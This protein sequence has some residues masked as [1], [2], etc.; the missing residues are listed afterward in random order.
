MKYEPQIKQKIRYMEHHLNQ[1][2]TITAKI[3]ENED[4]IPLFAN[5]HAFFW[6]CRSILESVALDVFDK[7]GDKPEHLNFFDAY[8]KHLKGKIPYTD[9]KMAE[10]KNDKEN[11]L[12]FYL[13]NYRNAI[14]HKEI[15]GRLISAS[16]PE[17]TIKFKPHRFNEKTGQFDTSW[18]DMT[19][20]ELLS[21]I[22]KMIT[23]IKE[24]CY[25]F[26]S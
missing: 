3:N 12:L 13:N 20:N 7:K 1:V 9:K 21:D 2:K 10:K 16:I 14:T 4:D 15:P 25:T 5:I 8:K 19:W 18:T 26:L 22:S 23:K 24:E 11:S 17:G 6:E